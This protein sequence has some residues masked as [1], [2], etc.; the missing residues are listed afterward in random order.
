MADELNEKGLSLDSYNVLLSNIQNSM[1]EIYAFDGDL[2]NFDS[3]TP[4]GQFTNILAQIGTDARQLA[5]EV[6]NSFNPDTC[7]GVIQDQRY[8]INYINKIVS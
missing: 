1:N 3:E 7:Q 5:I 4:D 8:A 6:Y 2:I